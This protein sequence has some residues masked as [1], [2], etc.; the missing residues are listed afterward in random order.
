MSTDSTVNRIKHWQT[1]LSEGKVKVECDEICLKY[2]CET[3]EGLYDAIGKGFRN[4]EYQDDA[5]N[6]MTWIN[7]DD[8]L[9][10]GALATV[11]QVCSENEDVRWLTGIRQIFDNLKGMITPTVAEVFPKYF[12]AN[13]LCDGTH[14]PFVQQEG[15]FWTY[16]LYKKVG[17][18]D[19]KLKCVGDYDLWRRFGQEEDLLVIDNVLGVF[20]KQPGQKSENIDEYKKEINACMDFDDRASKFYEILYKSEKK[21]E[22]GLLGKKASFSYDEGRWLFYDVSLSLESL[23]RKFKY[24]YWKYRIDR[25]SSAGNSTSAASSPDT[26]HRVEA[27]PN[28]ARDLGARVGA[29]LG[30]LLNKGGAG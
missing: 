27:K 14:F 21:I 25:R 4:C 28:S 18:L 12:L 6:V 19:P 3:D 10:Q 5:L 22:E 2:I 26:S 1:S 13:G 29:L 30:K 23:S 24:R 20:R 17:G 11:C 7:G 8:F 16:E 15:T 9:T